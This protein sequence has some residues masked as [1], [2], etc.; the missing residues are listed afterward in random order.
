[1]INRLC[2]FN[3]NILSGL[4]ALDLVEVEIYFFSLI[5]WSPEHVIEGSCDFVGGGLSS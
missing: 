3:D 5:T 1:M 4:V 2:D